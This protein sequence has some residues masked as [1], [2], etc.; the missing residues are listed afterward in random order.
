MTAATEPRL[1]ERL[2]GFAA[3]RRSLDERGVDYEIVRHEPTGSALAEARSY[4]APPHRGLKT[5]RLSHP[6][7][8]DIGA[9]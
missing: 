1:A 7:V 5:V 4:G 9:G 2:H 3:V 6:R 8:A